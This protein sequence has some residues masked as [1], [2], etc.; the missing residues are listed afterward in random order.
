MNA[1]QD[2]RWNQAGSYGSLDNL[3]RSTMSLDVPEARTCREARE[4]SRKEMHVLNEKL[5]SQLERMRFLSEQNR[6]LM[7]QTN[8]SR[9]RINK[10]TEKLKKTYETEMRQLRQLVDDCEREKADSLAKMATLQQ[11]LRYAEDQIKHLTQENKKL[12]HQLDQALKV[13]SEKEADNQMLQRHAKTAEDDAERF[14]LVADQAK[15]NN[16]KL[17]ANLDEETASR[18]ACQSE[19]QT[20]REE[21]EFLKTV[22]EQEL[23]ELRNITVVDHQ[24]DRDQ[25]KDEMQRAI[26]DIQTEYDQRLDRIRKEMDASYANRIAEASRNNA[27]QS[28]HFTQLLEENNTLKEAIEGMRKR[29]EQY[30]VKS[31]HYERVVTDAQDEIQTLRKK[32]DTA[33][34][35]SNRE[36][37]AAEEAL[38]RALNELSALTDAKLNLE[39]EIAAYRRLLEAQDSLIGGVKPPNAVT[40]EAS[41]VTYR[42]KELRVRVP[43]YHM[44][45][46]AAS[47]QSRSTKTD[48]TS[49][50][51]WTE[52]DEPSGQSIR[53]HLVER[54]VEGS[55]LLACSYSDSEKITPEQDENFSRGQL[56]FTEC[57]QNG[58]FIEICNT[59]N[60]DVGLSGWCLIRN[61]DHGRSIIRYTFPDRRIP[62]HHTFR[63]W[64][65]GKGG[66]NTGFLDFE[67]PYSSW[68]TGSVVHTSLFSPD[69][70]EKASHTQ[71]VDYSP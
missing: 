68:G 43:S 11:N 2:N 27:A 25:W 66:P 58:A 35:D 55:Q 67:A 13:V 57:A 8:G 9:G 16:E 56:A 1:S 44:T 46:T 18:M 47:A 26:R 63:I 62:P 32:L 33:L 37:Q 41:Q 34:R 14:R 61:I 70:M 51:R 42:P 48:S 65:S 22:H 15:Q 10:E 20:L 40:V 64:A 54:T 5:A 38:N 17:H 4:Q 59:G 21:M 19:M 49:I 69:G 12:S 30:R 3:A 31:E 7:E 45:H 53:S 36:R 39:S 60:C 6:K 52:R 24:Q 71:R 28:S 50:N 23:D 29:L